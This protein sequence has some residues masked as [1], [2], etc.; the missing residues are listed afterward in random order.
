MAV[1]ST[2]AVE[3]TPPAAIRFSCL[4]FVGSVNWDLHLGL[5][6]WDLRDL[7]NDVLPYATWC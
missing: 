5:L 7:H 4:Q 3:M 2:C 1:R 6:N